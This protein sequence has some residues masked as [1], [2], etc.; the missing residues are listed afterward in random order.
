MSTAAMSGMDWRKVKV[1]AK[2]QDDTMLHS[3]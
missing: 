3:P 2:P 1:E